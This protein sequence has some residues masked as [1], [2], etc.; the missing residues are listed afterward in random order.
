MN[1]AAVGAIIS[2]FI[3]C[4]LVQHNLMSWHWLGLGLYLVGIV[5][6]LIVLNVINK[7]ERK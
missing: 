3:S 7:G 1:V 4:I 6:I 2:L 5:G